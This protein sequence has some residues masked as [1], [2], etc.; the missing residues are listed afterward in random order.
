MELPRV[1]TIILNWNGLADTMECLAS[2]QKLDYPN[3]DIVVVDNGSTDKSVEVIR[4]NFPDVTLIENKENLGFVGGNNVGLHHTLNRDVDY[5][6]LLNNDTIVDSRFLVELIKVLEVDR[7]IG[8][9]SPL[10]FYY[11]TPDEIWAA[12]AAINWANGFTERLRAGDTADDGEPVFDVDFVSGCALLAKREVIEATGLLDADFFLYYE[13]IDWCVRAHKKGYRI[14]C[15]PQARIWHKVSKSIGVSSPL[16][17]Y[18]MTRN[19]LLFLKKHLSGIQL[20]LALQRNLAL[21]MRSVL[22]AYIKQK[23]AHRRVNARAQFLG[24]WDFARGRFG[25]AQ[26]HVREALT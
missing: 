10:I 5:V 17:S 25:A 16:V 15:V 4:K 21:T 20:G 12:G 2:L 13:E 19:A 18:Y 23:N 1:A 26:T 14:V 9:A 8:I 22:S 7:K 6:L 11:D 3:Y 24:V